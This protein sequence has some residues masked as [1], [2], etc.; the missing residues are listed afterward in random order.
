MLSDFARDSLREKRTLMMFG[1]SS[2]RRMAISLKQRFASAGLCFGCKYD[3]AKNKTMTQIVFVTCGMQQHGRLTWKMSTMRLMTTVSGL[4]CAKGS[5]NRARHTWP[6]EPS[7]TNSV[8]SYLAVT[9]HST[10]AP[11]FL[12][13]RYLPACEGSACA[14]RRAC[15]C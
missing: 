8:I 14:S 3:N 15:A 13:I 1:W 12:Q 9:F 5:A 4:P 2:L 7:P 11:P 10:A 6:N